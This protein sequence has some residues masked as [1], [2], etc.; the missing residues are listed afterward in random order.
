MLKTGILGKTESFSTNVDI[1]RRQAIT[2]PNDV[3]ADMT[4]ARCVI[5]ADGTTAAVSAYQY[6]KVANLCKWSAVFVFVK[7]ASGWTRQAKLEP[8]SQ[9]SGAW[10][11]FS[12]SLNADGN[13]LAIS[14]SH[15]LH[16]NNPYIDIYVY[17]RSGSVWDRQSKFLNGDGT[18]S[19]YQYRSVKLSYDGRT[20]FVGSRGDR[21]DATFTAGKGAV[22]VYSKT[23]SSWN[24]QATLVPGV[25]TADS[26]FGDGDISISQDGRT[27]AI[28]AGG[29]DGGI[30]KTDDGRLF[31]FVKNQDGAWVQSS[32]IG[33]EPGIGYLKFGHESS[34]SSD[35][36]SIVIGVSSF[37]NKPSGCFA[38]KRISNSWALQGFL[39]TDKQDPSL[40]LKEK[41]QLLDP[42]NTNDWYQSSFA[43][44]SLSISGDRCLVTDVYSNGN[45]DFIRSGEMYLYQKFG[46]IWQRVL[47][48]SET[49]SDLNQFGW[50]SAI[51]PDGKGAILTEQG[52]GN[53][54][55]YEFG[56][57]LQS[58]TV[59][60]VPAN[61]K[62]ASV[63]IDTCG[64][65]VSAFIAPSNFSD[66]KD[67]TVV[68]KTDKK[69][70]ATSAKSNV[71][72]GPGES[73]LFA[74][75]NDAAASCVVT[76]IEHN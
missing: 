17:V 45:G 38:Y 67:C 27:L 6:D 36:N 60:K 2:R 19:A 31:V 43:R 39:P 16:S 76:G 10:F 72:L 24:L 61:V 14:T 71:I 62:F 73:V 44:G 5:S 64:N 65:G 74:H 22:Y 32:V 51:Y 35:G 57:P 33:A 69:S 7:S 66:G 3:P 20:L 18:S 4:W 63:D 42:G 9:V 15:P 8:D 40:Q 59:Y 37:G 49:A 11:G 28:P 25:N 55:I 56:D 70:R 52:T 41:A 21:T 13:T 30:N 75:N 26:A 58:A 54:Y 34:L 50:S 53:F 1:I 68:V 23:G 12:L 46:T 48:I 47:C 29:Y